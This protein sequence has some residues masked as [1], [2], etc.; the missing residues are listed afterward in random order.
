MRDRVSPAS[1]VARVQTKG[2]PVVPNRAELADVFAL[3]FISRRDAEWVAAL[4]EDSH[5]AAGANLDRR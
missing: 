2:L 1:L 5:R 3:L 4:D